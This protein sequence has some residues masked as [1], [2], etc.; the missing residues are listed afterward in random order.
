MRFNMVNYQIRQI[1]KNVSKTCLDRIKLICDIFGIIFECFKTEEN[2]YYM[3]PDVVSLFQ[4]IINTINMNYGS[5]IRERSTDI[6][7]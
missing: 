3:T 1:L 5:Q 7:K 4:F 6:G 2:H